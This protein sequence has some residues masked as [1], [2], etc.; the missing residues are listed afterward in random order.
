MKK[1]IL[2]LTSMVIIGCGTDSVS[3]TFCYDKT[4]YAIDVYGTGQYTEY[5]EEFEKQ[6]GPN[7]VLACPQCT[8]TIEDC[9]DG[10]FNPK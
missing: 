3:G 2:A 7:A 1:L 5:R 8:I 6:H 9:I 4:L 10:T